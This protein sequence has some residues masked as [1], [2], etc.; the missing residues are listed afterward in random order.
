MDFA[1]P[2]DSRIKLKESEKNDKYHDFTREFKKKTV[3]HEMT[4]FVIGSLVDL[5][6]LAVNQTSVKEHQLML[7]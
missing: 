3:E 7:I 6:R 2:A 5:R 4:P 1:V